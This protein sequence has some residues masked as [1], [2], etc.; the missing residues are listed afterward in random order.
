MLYM[1]FSSDYFGAER[2]YSCPELTENAHKPC[3]IILHWP[4]LFRIV[5]RT[6]GLFRRGSA[7]RES[8]ETMLHNNSSCQLKKGTKGRSSGVK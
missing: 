3:L 7:N 1:V 6:L 8:T 4:G 2:A 5:T